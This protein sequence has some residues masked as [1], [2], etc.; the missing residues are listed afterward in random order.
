MPFPDGISRVSQSTAPC[1]PYAE[2]P[3]GCVLPRETVQEK[4]QRLCSQTA[5]S[6]TL[7]LS[8][9]TCGWRKHTMLQRK[10]QPRTGHLSV[11][12]GDRENLS[13]PNDKHSSGS[14]NQREACVSILGN[15]LMRNKDGGRPTR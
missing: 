14:Q 13:T 10:Q 5:W 2:G 6:L 11:D 7:V 15:S 12:R 3:P 8:L 9:T 1:F 4:E